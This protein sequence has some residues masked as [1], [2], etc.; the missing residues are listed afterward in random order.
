METGLNEIYAAGECVETWHRLLKRNVYLPFGATAQKQGRVAGENA[1]GGCAA[2]V[3]TLGT[4][5]VKIFDIVVA[6][7]GLR[8]SEAREA[9]FDPITAEVEAWDHEVKHP[10]ATPLRI[11]ITGDR[12]SH[13]LLGAQI[14]GHYK[15]GVSRRIDVFAT[16]IS[17]EMSVDAML[18]LDLSYSPPL[19]GS[20]DPVQ[21]AALEWIK[22]SLINRA[23]SVRTGLNSLR[24]DKA[25]IA[26]RRFSLAV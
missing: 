2:F 1:A 7:T 6:R 13:Q 19:G 11:R 3:G 20:L 25:V 24:N 18:D 26:E 5:S 9:G 10:G 23:P 15:G 8:D 21:R 4:H 17:A 16:A 12:R 22:G 14:V